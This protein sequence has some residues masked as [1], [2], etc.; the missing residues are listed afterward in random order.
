MK[1]LI[2]TLLIGFITLS[3]YSQDNNSG[4]AIY[5]FKINK[6]NNKNLVA[7]NKKDAI[8]KEA[9][10]LI[11]SALEDSQELKFK[12]SFNAKESIFVFQDEMDID[13]KSGISTVLLNSMAGVDEK[14]YYKRK[15]KEIYNQTILIGET[16]LIK[17]NSDSLKWDVTNKKRIINNY[18]CF[19]AKLSKTI[20]HLSGDTSKEDIIVWYTPSVKLPLGPYGYLGLPGLVIEVQEKLRTIT[21]TKLKFTKKAPKITPLVKGI[22]T[23][24]KDLLIDARKF[25]FKN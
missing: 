7:K 14:Y 12:L 15:T 25:M 21:L 6:N 3:L 10:D 4:Y 19:K 24:E 22:K 9:S 16:F 18:T 1:K 13:D 20:Y 23:T 17:S 2:F 11:K 8:Q 5:N